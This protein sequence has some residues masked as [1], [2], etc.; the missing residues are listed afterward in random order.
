M[1]ESSKSTLGVVI[2]IVI[3]LL[4]A[5]AGALGLSSCMN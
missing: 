1:K 3:T 5:L 4:T 2:K